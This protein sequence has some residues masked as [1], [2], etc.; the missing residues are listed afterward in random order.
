MID[1]ISSLIESGTGEV[2]VNMDSGATFE[3]HGDVSFDGSEIHFEDGDGNLFY[4]DGEKV[5]YIY[6]HPSHRESPA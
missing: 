3:L 4:L 2:T 5:E 6:C 1:R